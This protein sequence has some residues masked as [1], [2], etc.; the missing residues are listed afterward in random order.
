VNNSSWEEIEREHDLP[1]PLS[2]VGANYV[3][4][5][6]QWYWSNAGACLVVMSKSGCIQG[7]CYEVYYFNYTTPVI[8]M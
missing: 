3:G 6:Q 1:L 5:N 4:E 8:P 2:A 7:C